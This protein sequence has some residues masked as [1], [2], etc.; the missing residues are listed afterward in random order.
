[1]AVGGGGATSVE[2]ASQSITQQISSSAKEEVSLSFRPAI[3]MPILDTSL[4]W[5]LPAD[6]CGKPEGMRRHR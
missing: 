2:K 3:F 5:Y 1:M 6:E 4:M